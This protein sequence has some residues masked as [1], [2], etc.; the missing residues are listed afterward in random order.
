MMRR[1]SC[2]CNRSYSTLPTLVSEREWPCS[3]ALV[4]S[5][6]SSRMPSP[7]AMAPMRARSVRRPSTGVRSSLKSPVC[8]IVPCG[9]WN[10]VANP[11]GTEWVT[12]MNSTSNGPIWRRSPSLDG[13]ELGPL[14]QAGLLDAAPGQAERELGAEDRE[15]QLRSRYDSAPTWSSWPWVSDAAD[16]VV[17]RSTQPGEVGQHEVD[18]EHVGVGEHEP[19]VE[20]QDAALDLDHGAVA[21]DL[22]EAA[23]EGDVNGSWHQLRS[24]EHLD[25]RGPRD[26]RATG[27]DRQ[28]ALADLAARARAASPWSGMGFGASSLPSKSYEASR[29]ALIRRAASTSPLS[30]ASIISPSWR[31]T[32]C[33]A[34]EMTPTAPTASSGSVSASSPL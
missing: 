4:E 34:T 8:R 2:S 22:A 12:G 27:P 19:A 1:P 33:D 18:A 15:R 6:S 14:E 32:Q 30:K 21:A 13:D 7:S 31:P 24:V 3:S 20:E 5:D 25:G 28:A 10:A 26:L 9:V 16:D 11:W 29:P 23:E 17:G